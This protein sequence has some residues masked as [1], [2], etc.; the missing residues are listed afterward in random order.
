MSAGCGS[1]FAQPLCL[2]DATDVCGNQGVL[3]LWSG[4][5]PQQA[6]PGEALGC[7]QEHLQDA[8]GKK[9]EA[10]QQERSNNGL[11]NNSF[12]GDLP[13]V[14]AQIAEGADVN[15]ALPE[16]KHTPL[17][18]ASRRGHLSVVIALVAA[19]AVVDRVDVDGSTALTVAAHAG[20]KAVVN[21]LHRMAGA[22]VHHVNNLG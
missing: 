20:H 10:G 6:V 21:A 19:R 8:R 11:Y 9:A 7:A 17:H 14:R 16:T 18:V 22:S 1:G 13:T 12:D 3:A 5:L 15:W 4:P 2:P